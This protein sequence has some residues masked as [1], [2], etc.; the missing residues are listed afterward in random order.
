LF[1]FHYY[2]VVNNIYQGAIT[3]GENGSGEMVGGIVEIGFIV[4][5][6]TFATI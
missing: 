6:M 1:V 4:S 5:A 3:P 2:S